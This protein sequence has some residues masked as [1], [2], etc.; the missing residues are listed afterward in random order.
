MQGAHGP[1]SLGMA[2]LSAPEI[3][4][5]RDRTVTLDASQ[6]PRRSRPSSRR[7]PRDADVPPGHLPGL[8]PTDDYAAT[9]TLPGPA[10]TA[11]GR[12][13]P[14]RRSPRAS[15]TF[16]ARWRKEQ[17][18]PDGGLRP[19]AASTTC[20]SSAP[21]RR[22]PRD[23]W[24]LDAVFAGRG[25]R[26][27]LRRAAS[28]GQGRRGAPQRRRHRASSR[29]PPPWRPARDCCWSST[30]GSVGC[31]PWTDPVWAPPTARASDGGHPHPR[32]GRGADRP[33]PARQ[34]PADASSPS[35]T[36]DYLYDLVHH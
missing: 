1:H 19:R 31:E 28:S 21:R 13:P 9:P 5:D 14:A 18:P 27:R 4:L 10:T 16:G 11:S 22:C 33:D 30:T 17:P 24:T 3:I 12:C 8:R 2:M 7:R 23:G 34:G 25:R 29:R 6:G 36:T 32:R 15:S 26:G 20:G 35:P